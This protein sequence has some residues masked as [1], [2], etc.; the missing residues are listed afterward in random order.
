MH[1]SIMIAASRFADLL[2]L[3]AKYEGRGRKLSHK[4]AVKDYAPRVFT[5]EKVVLAS[6]GSARDG[7]PF[8]AQGN[9]RSGPRPSI[10]GLVTHRAGRK[11]TLEIIYFLWLPL[12]RAQIA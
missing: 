2:D 10:S 11:G 12:R 6:N 9:P 4:A 8:R 7:A 5:A 3:L 1:R